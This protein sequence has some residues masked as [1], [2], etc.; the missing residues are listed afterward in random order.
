MCECVLRSWSSFTTDSQ[1]ASL[2]WCRALIW[3]SLPDFCFF[4]DNCGFLDVGH[5]L[6]REDGSVIYSYNWFWALPQDS[7]S[8]FTVSFETPQLGGPGHHIY[9]TQ[10]QGGP[11]VPAGTAFHSRRLLRLTGLRWRYS[12]PPPFKPVTTLCKILPSLSNKFLSRTALA[13]WKRINSRHLFCLYSEVSCSVR[14]VV[15][16]ILDLWG[17]SPQPVPA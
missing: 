14:D 11:V 4:S 15:G 17:L 8:Y 7:W 12:N 5:P 1:S 13:D 2:S 10:K 16:Q 3:T 9:I 6:W